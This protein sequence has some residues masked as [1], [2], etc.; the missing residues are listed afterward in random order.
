MNE[1]LYAQGAKVDITFG[2]F[3]V[4]PH[5][6]SSFV[7]LLCVLRAFVLFFFAPALLLQK[8]QKHTFSFIQSKQK[9]ERRK[10]AAPLQP[11]PPL[12]LLLCSTGAFD[13]K[14]EISLDV[15]YCNLFVLLFFLVACFFFTFTFTVVICSLCNLKYVKRGYLIS[16]TRRYEIRRVYL[17]H[18][19]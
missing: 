17:F 6:S 7:P 11:P 1:G 4:T 14:P 16:R 2:G 5:A 13:V 9:G 18:F 3:I 10:I 8:H 12:H 15:T 19:A